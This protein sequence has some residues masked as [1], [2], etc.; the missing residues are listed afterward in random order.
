MAL[1]SDELLQVTEFSSRNFEFEG[2]KTQSVKGNLRKNLSFWKTIGASRFILDVVEHGYKLPFEKLPDVVRL[3]N[4][5]SAEKHALFVHEAIS[6]L[7]SSGR[8]VQLPSAPQV[9][10]PLSVAVQESGKRRLILD[11][12]HVNQ[13]LST[14]RVKYEDWKI[15]LAYYERQ[16][17]MFTF[18][19]KSGYHH[20]DIFKE[21]QTYLGFA[22]RFPASSQDSFFVFTVLPFGLST[23]PHI[24]TKVV[25]PLEK[26]WRYSGINIAIF[27]DDGWSVDKN[28][29]TCRSNARTVRHDLIRAGFVPNDDK[30]V[31]EPTQVLDW[32][33]L[34]WNAAEGTLSIVPRR[35]QKIFST[36]ERIIELAFKISARQLAAL[37]VGQIISTGAVMGNIARIMTR[38]SSMSIACALDM[39]HSV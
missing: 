9:V 28:L 31:W 23:A 30:S 29:Q 20:I 36:I 2:G 37:Q 4:N 34:T 19:L 13:C 1:S 33:G 14:K 24:F 25:K 38:H 27:L 26:H 11:L 8:I 35:I 16:A 6:E 32:L 5:K 21:H 15:A 39:G 7:A 3:R 18:D 10:N 17:Y 22:W 12:R